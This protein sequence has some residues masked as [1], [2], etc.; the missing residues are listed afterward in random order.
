[1]CE[2]RVRKGG[3]AYQAMLFGEHM[4]GAS[5]PPA[6]ACLLAEQFGHDLLGGHIFAERMDMVSVG[7][8]DIVFTCQ[9]SYNS[10]GHSFL[11]SQVAHH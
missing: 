9:Q 8:A 3:T 2:T 11:H 7:G 10:C 4:H 5:L 1:M 6:D